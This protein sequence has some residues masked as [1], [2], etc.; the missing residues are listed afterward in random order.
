MAVLRSSTNATSFPLGDGRSKVAWE[1]RSLRDDEE[2]VESVN[3]AV[4]AYLWH[5][6]GV[7]L[8]TSVQERKKEKKKLKSHFD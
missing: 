7:R 4:V 3:G 8:F 5:N 2:N 6:R 1:E